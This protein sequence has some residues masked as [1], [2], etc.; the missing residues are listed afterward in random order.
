MN[1]IAERNKK[2]L[3]HL[4]VLKSHLPPFCNAFFVGIGGRTQPLTRLNYAYDLGNFFNY[5]SMESDIHR[6]I[7]TINFT[8]DDLRSVEKRH[9]ELYMEW[10]EKNGND[11]RGRSRKQSCLRTF[12]AYYFKNGDLEKNIMPNIDMPKIHSKNIIRLDDDEA[13]RIVQSAIT[14]D[15]L[16]K[17]QMRFHN[18][19]SFRDQVILTFLLETG[20]RVS[21]IVGLNVGDIDLR[22]KLFRVTRK[23]GN[24]AVLYLT[25]K[26]TK[27]LEE[28]LATKPDVNRPMFLGPD[29]KTR[30]G[31]RSIQ[32]L[33]QKYASHAAPL[34]NISPHKLRST[35]GTKLYQA[36]NDI[37]AVAETLGHVN[38]NTT[39]KHYADIT[40]KQKRDA[41]A[42]LD[43]FKEEN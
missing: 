23:G 31:V 10:L 4:E 34:K 14:G 24:Q 28:Y 30:L 12:F 21:E 37:Y 20:V 33:V 1:Y 9:I 8:I 42:M 2:T 25:T 17:G 22:N 41:I 35:F 40:E 43:K 29:G 5:L 19:N 38:V 3:E 39:R 13:K 32:N 15:E 27:L 11:E 18:K 36:T 16:T 7:D 26:L 6:D